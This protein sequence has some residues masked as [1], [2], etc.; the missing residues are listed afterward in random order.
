LAAEAGSLAQAD[1][2][3]EKK[4]EKKETKPEEKKA[5]AKAAQAKPEEKAEEKKEDSPE[6]K[7]RKEAVAVQKTQAAAKA[8]GDASFL[9]PG[10]SLSI[11]DVVNVGKSYTVEAGAPKQVAETSSKISS[12]QL[13]EALAASAAS[14]EAKPT[15]DQADAGKGVR[16]ELTNEDGA[17]Y[18]GTIYVGA[19]DAPARVLF[20]TGSDFLALT[21]DLCLDPKLGKQEVD[22]PVFDK[23]N[24]TYKPSG[25][26]LRKCKSTAYMSKE[27]PSG[28]AL[29][30]DDEKLDYG[31]AKL[32]GKLYSDRTCIDAN[33]T[34]CTDFSFLALYQAQGLDDTDGVLGLAVH[35]DA[36]RKNLSY[37]W[38]LKN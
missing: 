21:S 9:D 8:L 29:G 20:D 2:A 10:K 33:K 5:E 25:K 35:P 12:K 14:E 7:A 27:S 16:V 4:E 15:P 13:T 26:D 28:K 36:T 31:S 11:T 17:G 37:V 30:G 38:Q 18:V 19:N 23:E 1:K 22:E 32:Q 34:A 24:L 6:E 3:N